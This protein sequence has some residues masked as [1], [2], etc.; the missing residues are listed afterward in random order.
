MVAFKG[1]YLSLEWVQSL[2]RFAS[3]SMWRD[4]DQQESYENEALEK[5]SFFINFHPLL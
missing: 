2:V 1:M 3:E 5:S 4:D